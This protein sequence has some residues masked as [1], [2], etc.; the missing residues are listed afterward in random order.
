MKDREVYENPLTGRYATREMRKVFSPDSRFRTW[1]R[2][3]IALARAE[4]R[5]G[6]PIEDSQIAELTE[7]RDEID[8]EVAEKKE[9][10]I[11]HDVMACC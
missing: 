10:E 1:R 7:H 11:R 2:L 9:Q 6:L 3:W 5:L 8:Y 4:Q